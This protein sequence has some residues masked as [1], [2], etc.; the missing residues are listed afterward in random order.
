MPHLHAALPLFLGAALLVQG[1]DAIGD[2][3][4]SVAALF[5][6]APAPPPPAPDAQEL[7]QLGLAALRRGDITDAVAELAPAA[8]EGD[9]TAAVAL[10]SLY[11]IGLGVTRDYG[12]AS[13]WFTPAAEAGNAQAQY[14]LGQMA[15]R[16]GTGVVRNV[17]QAIEWYR[18][19]AANGLP[20]AQ[21][22]LG[23]LY[24]EGLSTPADPVQARVWLQ[25]AADQGTPQAMTALGRIYS[26]GRGVP[27]DD[28]TA[29]GWYRRAADL[30]DPAAMNAL[31]EAYDIGTGVPRDE[32]RALSWYRRAADA[33]NENA[34]R[35]LALPLDTPPAGGAPL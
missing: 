21:Y 33:G 28:S 6:P 10:G 12:E 22:R 26:Q 27:A 5:S 23:L 19:A 16:G 7:T 24:L 13:Q 1:C 34:A 8:Q 15:E 29:L 30:G 32:T 9:T 35:R 20:E 31:G 14:H 25:R 2:A 17:P 4:D 3:S 18:Q 11:F